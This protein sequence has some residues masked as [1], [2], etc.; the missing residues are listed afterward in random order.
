MIT[1][2]MYTQ[3]TRIRHRQRPEWGAGTI[4]RIEPITRGT[5]RDQR[6]WIQFASAGS[7]M[8]LASAADLEVLEGGAAEHTFAAREVASERGWLGQIASKKPEQAMTEL[9]PDATDPFLMPERRLRNLLTLYR[10]DASRLI[11]WA[12]AQ[13]GLDDPLS[14]F[15]RVELEAFFK[16]WSTARDVALAR[17]VGDFR[18]RRVPHEA[19]L[20]GA[21]ARG[22]RG[23][24]EVRQDPLNRRRPRVACMHQSARPEFRPR[25]LFLDAQESRRARRGSFRSP[26]HAPRW[27]G[28]CHV[29]SP[30]ICGLRHNQRGEGPWT[31]PASRTR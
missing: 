21:P 20:A 11:D 13:S 18:R 4:T 22:P 24:A 16:E 30:L 19:L 23:V 15:N 26:A 5:S 9:P 7:K 27:H 31:R 29:S 1:P 2:T 12:V 10:F 14:R 3:G 17:L 6:L 8:L 25:G 28:G